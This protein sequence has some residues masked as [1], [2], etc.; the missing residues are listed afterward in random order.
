MPLDEVEKE[1]RPYDGLTWERVPRVRLVPPGLEEC[2]KRVPRHDWEAV[3]ARRRMVLEE[4][5]RNE[6]EISSG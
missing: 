4:R 2:E 3:G 1:A 5:K 6:M